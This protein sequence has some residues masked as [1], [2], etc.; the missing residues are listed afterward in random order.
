M[1]IQSYASISIKD[2]AKSVI[3]SDENKKTDVISYDSSLEIIGRGRS[4]FVFKL[5]HANKVIKVFYPSFEHLAVQEAQIYEVL[6]GKAHFPVLYEKGPN[7][8]VIDYLEGFTFFQCLMM[9]KTITADHVKE[10]DKAILEARDVGLNPS[11]IHLHNLMI[12]SDH[13]VKLVD[14]ARF[15]QDKQCRQWTDL[16]YAFTHYYSKRFFPKRFPAFLLYFVA[17]C[18]KKY[19]AFKESR[20]TA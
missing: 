1:P 5:P 17:A 14:V 4:A 19:E 12:T 3:F 18:Y 7:Y 9:G 2:L 20:G 10:V 13:S 16:K 6:Q 11:D 8:I 15:K